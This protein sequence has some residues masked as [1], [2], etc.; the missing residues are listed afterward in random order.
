M[1]IHTSTAVYILVINLL[2]QR[3]IEKTTHLIIRQLNLGEMP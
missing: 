3:L 1:A 2:A